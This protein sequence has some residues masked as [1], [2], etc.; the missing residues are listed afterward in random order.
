MSSRGPI[1]PDTENGISEQRPVQLCANLI[2]WL[3]PVKGGRAPDPGA[4]SEPIACIAVRVTRRERTVGA[5]GG[6]LHSPPP[7]ERQMW[8]RS[9]RHSWDP[10]ALPHPPKTGSPGGGNCA[11]VTT[12]RFTGSNPGSAT[13]KL[14]HLEPER[15]PAKVREALFGDGRCCLPS[16]H[17][18]LTASVKCR[19][20]PPSQGT[21]ARIKHANIHENHQPGN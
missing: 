8:R 13:Y 21:V 9:E 19:Q 5:W 16:V 11:V 3:R 2:L 12:F 1:T 10:F 18:P 7:R 17:H 6:G 15:R 20:S 14:C 4:E